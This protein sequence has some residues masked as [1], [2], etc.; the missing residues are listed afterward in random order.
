[1]SRM[2]SLQSSLD[3]PAPLHQ[4]AATA[5]GEL[6]CLPGCCAAAAVIKY[7]R[8]LVEPLRRMMLKMMQLYA[9]L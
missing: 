9:S 8:L 3:Q 5:H 7:V 1:M 4:G 2:Q 6:P